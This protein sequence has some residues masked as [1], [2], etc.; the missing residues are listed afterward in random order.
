MEEK[1]NAARLVSSA[2]LGIDGET[3]IIADK[4]YFIKPPTIRKIAGAANVLSGFGGK[5]AKDTLSMMKDIGKACEAL[6]WF[7]TGDDSLTGELSHG[8]LGEVVRGLETAVG[9]LSIRDF[10]TLS[11]LSR[12]VQR[13][14]ANPKP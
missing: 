12:S 6:S 8:T 10:Q 3:V 4:A 13:L 1:N 11:T 14:A 5:D 7:I 2:I 9:L